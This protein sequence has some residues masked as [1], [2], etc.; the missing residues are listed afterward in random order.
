M[1]AAVYADFRDLEDHHWWFVARKRIF[2]YVIERLF[3]DDPRPPAERRVMDLGCGM[4]NMLEELSRHG[5]VLGSDVMPDALAHCRER[6]F[7]GLFQATGGHLPLADDTLDLVTL[8]DTLEHIPEE[9]ETLQELARVVRPGGHVVFSVPAYQCLYSHQDKVVHHQR[10]YTASDLKRKLRAAGF[11]VVRASYINF[12]LFPLILPAVLLIKLK[13][14]LKPPE[15]AA[16]KTNV[17]WPLPAFVH[18]MLAGIFAF[19]RH[20]IMRCPAPTGHSL[21]V[22]GRRPKA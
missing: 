1:E 8:F 16:A 9:R 22:V 13:E 15:E 12:F 3:R 18:K 14:W 5:R 7:D 10:R 20:I 19:E 11:E 21:L 17:N 2:S 6:G 4:G